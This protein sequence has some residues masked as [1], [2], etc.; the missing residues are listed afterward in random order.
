MGKK[1]YQFPIIPNSELVYEVRVPDSFQCLKWIITPEERKRV[2]NISEVDRTQNEIQVMFDHLNKME[3]Q[4]TQ[5]KFLHDNFLILNN[6]NSKNNRNLLTKLGT[7]AIVIA[8]QMKNFT[9]LGNIAEELKLRSRSPF[10]EVASAFIL[11]RSRRVS[12]SNFGS[13]WPIINK[14]NC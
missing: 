1:N 8:A 4:E 3:S 7:Q 12:S 5:I 14:E 10:F 13:G 2:H 6:I 9:L 11:D